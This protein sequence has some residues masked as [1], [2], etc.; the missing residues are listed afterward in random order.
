MSGYT[1]SSSPEVSLQI[2][3]RLAAAVEGDT[4]ALKWVDDHA[5]ARTGRMAQIIRWVSNQRARTHVNTS[6]ADFRF[7]IIKR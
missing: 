3:D 6:K 4:T 2:R 7:A 5:Y 1:L